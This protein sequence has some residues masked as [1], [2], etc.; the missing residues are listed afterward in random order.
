MFMYCI[1]YIYIYIYY[2]YI[3]YI[4]QTTTDGNH[5]A[6]YSSFSDVFVAV[7]YP[8]YLKMKELKTG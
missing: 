8:S 2:I 6:Q 7:P 4:Y 3:Y 5:V 1:F